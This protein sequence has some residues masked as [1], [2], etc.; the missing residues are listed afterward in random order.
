MRALRWFIAPVLL[1]S[2]CQWKGDGNDELIRDPFRRTAVGAPSGAGTEHRNFGVPEQQ[3][4]RRQ[5]RA[6]VQMER[7][8]GAKYVAHGE[9]WE[10][11]GTVNE[12]QPPPKL[13]AKGRKP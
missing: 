12:N 2:A 10:G 4:P 11:F 6:D 9:R 3:M 7:D 5:G 8:R 13:K 1:V